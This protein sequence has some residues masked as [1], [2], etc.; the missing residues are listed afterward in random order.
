MAS[1]LGVGTGVAVRIGEGVGVGLAD[2]IA[3]ALG[4]ARSAR[5]TEL[6]AAFPPQAV[7]PTIALVAKA[8]TRALR[9]DREGSG[10]PRSFTSSSSLRDAS[11]RFNGNSR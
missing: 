2:W 4:V 3:M 9:R 7:T 1:G 6:G 11:P 8:A 10:I 5:P